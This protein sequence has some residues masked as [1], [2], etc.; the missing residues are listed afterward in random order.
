MFSVK[1][2]AKTARSLEWLARSRDVD[3]HSLAVE[4]IQAHVRVEAQKAMEQEVE[5]FKKMHSQLMASIPGEYAAIYQGQLIDHD[6]DMLELLR[7]IESHYPGQPVLIRQ[8]QA[9]PDTTIYVRSPRIE[10]A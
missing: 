10:H 7:R 3:P 5:A 8:V 2:D 9:E 6:P 4:A 1:L